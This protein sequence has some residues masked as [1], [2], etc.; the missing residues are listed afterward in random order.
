MAP[1]GGERLVKYGK[2][3][4]PVAGLSIS[5]VVVRLTA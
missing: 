4:F 5:R 3:R 1:E 2:G